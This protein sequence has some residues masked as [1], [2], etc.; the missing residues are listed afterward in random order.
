MGEMP[1]TVPVFNT[2]SQIRDRVVP[3]ELPR[4]AVLT[5]GALHEG[6]L[7][8]M[9]AAQV[10][11][12]V[13]L[14]V[15]IFVNPLQFTNVTDLDTYPRSLESDL[16]LCA[17]AGVNAVFAP[18]VHE[19]YP[20]G[21]HSQPSVLAGPR[22]EILEGVFR[23]K[24]FDGVLTVVNKLI[25]ILTPDIMYF[26][27]KDYQ[28]LVLIR[29]MVKAF[30]LP[31]DI[32]GVPTVRESDGLARSSRNVRLSPEARQQSA[33]IYAALILA[34]HAWQE[35]AT[36]HHT[37]HIVREYLDSQP[38]IEVD[39]VAVRNDELE[40]PAQD[41]NARVLIAAHIGGVRLIDNLD[42]G[43]RSA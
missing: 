42:L 11:G 18:Q 17:E 4:A 3:A 21:F 6:H 15:S 34:Q 1:M 33:H 10:S 37:E 26:G 32:V 28:Q 23:P 27:E 13:D 36:V 41:Q 16:R 30:N 25:N 7:A 12:D 43:S 24:H 39:Y 40:F 35:G 38:G 8:L 31:V 20:E 9:Q 5:M 19:M 29:Q 2:I 22:G 14:V